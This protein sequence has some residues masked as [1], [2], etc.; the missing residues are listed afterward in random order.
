MSRAPQPAPRVTPFSRLSVQAGVVGGELFRVLGVLE[1]QDRSGTLHVRELE[2]I[3]I[4]AT[5]RILEELAIIVIPGRRR[6]LLDENA[7]EFTLE[8]EE[9]DT[10][11]GRYVVQI[12]DA[13][14][15]VEWESRPIDGVVAAAIAKGMEARVGNGRTVV[16]A[17][18][19][20]TGG[21][22]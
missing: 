22:G 21:D 4:T 15:Q 2:P 11:W 3:G 5:M 1:L 10:R 12:L 6:R 8:P 14:K 18:L 16:A 7:T 9:W 19:P 13:D 20:G 17:V